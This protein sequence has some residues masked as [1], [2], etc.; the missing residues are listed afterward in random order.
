MA[1]S[2]LDHIL[3]GPYKGNTRPPRG[4]DGHLETDPGTRTVGILS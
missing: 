1:I 3:S 4:G 2:F